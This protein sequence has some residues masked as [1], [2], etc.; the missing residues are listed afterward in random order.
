[1]SG[2]R[3]TGSFPGTPLL[4]LGVFLTSSAALLLEVSLTRLFSV[5]LWH[6]F[7]FMVVSMALLGYGASGSLLMGPLARLKGD[8]TLPWTAFGF[9]LSIPAAFSLGSLLPVDPPRLAWDAAQPFFLFGLFLLMA[10]PFFFAGLTLSLVLS[11][12][13]GRA[14]RIYLA[15]LSGAAVGAVLPLLLFPVVGP[16]VLI[17]ASGLAAAGGFIF[18]ARAGSRPGMVVLSLMALLAVGLAAAPPPGIPLSPYK[19]LSTLVSFPGARVTETRWDASSRVDV[20]ESPLVRFAPGLSLNRLDPLPP[21]IGLTVD[22]DRLTAVTRVSGEKDLAFARDLP[23]SLPYVLAPGGRAFVV[24]AGGGLDVLTAL[25]GGAARVTASF[26]NRLIARLLTDTLREASG[27]IFL[28]PRVKTVSGEPRNA[29]R[30]TQERFDVIHLSHLEA[31]AASSSALYGLGEDYRLTVDAAREYIDHLEP[32]GWLAISHYLLPPP[33]L[34]PRVTSLL[35]T[36]LEER[37]ILRPENHLASIRS[38]GTVVHLLKA[39]ELTPGDIKTIRSFAEEKRFDLVYY[40]GMKDAEAN[41]FNRFPKPIY[42]DLTRRIV[43]PA[44]R[45]ALYDRYPF[46]IRPVTD[47]RPFF[48]HFFRRDRLGEVY[49]VAGEKWQV[50]IEG[51]YIVPVLL[52]LA[53]GA[54][55]ILIL[56]PLAFRRTD[57]PN[58]LSGRTAVLG[59]FLAIGFGFILLEIALIQQAIRFLDHPTPAVAVVLASL[60]VSAGLGSRLSERIEHPRSLLPVLALA[61]FLASATNW[62]LPP[63]FEAFSGSADAVRYAVLAATLSPLGFVLGF[64]FPTA[65]RTL[66]GPRNLVPWAWAVN[67][68][69]SVVGGILAV[70]LALEVGFSG[71]RLLAAGF[72]VLAM[73]CLIA[74]LRRSGERTGHPAGGP[75]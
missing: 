29:L 24:E 52:V 12:H 21:Q 72:Y 31:Q 40:P 60:L 17:V 45:I 19:T 13:A 64:P 75:R 7:A 8:R 68:C 3:Q 23:A 20:V 44:E 74:G 33:R 2:G 42:E 9:S 65:I 61:A 14:G 43:D 35:V 36:A 6:H 30:R 62:V 26:S 70:V 51:G 38:W 57:R 1:M 15:D 37:G 63:V 55:V 41:R 53:G 5:I 48:F 39:S 32:D 56:L 73:G 54:S 69:A 46:D 18:A 16:A 66:A 50:F 59:Y 49:R 34:A 11:R 4:Y 47:D 27:G 58:G 67:G 10:V 28:D 22:G 71:V 25:G